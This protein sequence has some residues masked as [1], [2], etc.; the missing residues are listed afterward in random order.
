MSA[1]IIDL[2]SRRAMKSLEQKALEILNAALLDG[3]D[4]TQAEIVVDTAP[5]EYCASEDDSA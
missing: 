2:K 4:I 3:I 5:S 1:D